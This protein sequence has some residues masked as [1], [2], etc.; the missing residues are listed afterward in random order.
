MVFLVVLSLGC[1][2]YVYQTRYYLRFIPIP[3]AWADAVNEPSSLFPSFQPA[4]PA[5]KVDFGDF[6]ITTD[7]GLR[8]R[9]NEIQEMS[10]VESRTGIPVYKDI[11]F[12]K[13]IREITTKPFFC[14]DATQLF[15]LS[16]WAEGLQAREWHL[17]W[18][19]WLPNGGHSMAEFFNPVVG[20]WQLVDAQHSAIVRG[21]GHRILDMLTVI[22]MHEAGRDSEIS[23]DYGPYRERML[24]GAR[25]PSVETNMFGLGLLRTPVLQLRQATWLATPPKRFGIGGHP[26]IG[27][28]IIVEGW[29]HDHRVWISK[30]M[31][32][33]S[34]AFAAAAAIVGARVR[35]VSVADGARR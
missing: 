28:P 7:E 24:N 12:D 35:R 2:T 22:R 19:T 21:P 27:Y 29:T 26:I 5:G 18:P 16:A 4:T 13:W 33:F 10:P 23:I 25:G 31:L 9:L 34:V 30:V 14:T 6:S 1:A 15:L 17:L 20:R 11:D 32:F 8:R 3:L